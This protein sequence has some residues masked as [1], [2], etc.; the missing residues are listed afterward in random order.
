[1]IIEKAEVFVHSPG[2]NFVTLKV[3]TKSGLVGYGDATVN[4]RE[5]AVAAYLR[6]HLLPSLRLTGWTPDWYAG[7]PVGQ[8]YFPFPAVMIVVLDALTPLSYNVAF[9]LVSILGILLLP[10][11]VY[12]LMRALRAPFPV[13]SIAAGTRRQVAAMTAATGTTRNIPMMPAISLP[14]GI[15]IS[16]IAQSAVTTV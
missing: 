8:F 9:K 10:F 1:M 3:T 16:T 4:G 14:T 13:P 5:L 15:A 12:A 11:A 2:R 6:D 7:F